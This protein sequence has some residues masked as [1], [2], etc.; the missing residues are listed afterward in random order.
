MS[1]SEKKRGAPAAH[2][3]TPSA[4]F[5]GVLCKTAF[6]KVLCCLEET[7]TETAGRWYRDASF[8]LK[9]YESTAWKVS[10]W[11]GAVHAHLGASGPWPHLLLPQGL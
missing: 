4:L 11:E 10:Q 3:R 1:W 9:F 8:L 2:S 5:T 7:Q 6:D